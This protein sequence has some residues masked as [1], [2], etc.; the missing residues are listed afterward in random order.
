MTS[1]PTSED[2]MRQIWIP[3]PGPPEVLELREAPD[4]VPAHD[5]V[6]IRV[7]AA[8]VNFADIMGRMGMYPDL[9]RMPVVVGY[10][11]AGKID[12]FKLSAI[13]G[14]V[15][16]LYCLTLPHTPPA[17][18]GH[19]F[20]ISDALGLD[21]LAQMK[22]RSFA[23]FVIGS[24]LICIPLQFYYAF[25][26]LFLNESGVTNA[27]GKM[28]LGQMS[29]ILFMLLLPVFLMRFGT[30]NILLMGMA[31]WGARYLLFAHGNVGSGAW[32][33]YGGILLHGICYDF[34]FVTGQI[35]VDQQAS[36]KIRAAAQGFLTFLTQGV[37]YLIGSFASGVVVQ[38]FAIATGGHDW[39][40]IWLRPA[41]GAAIILVVFALVFRPD[42]TRKMEG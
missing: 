23:T 13:L 41:V 15:M 22:D 39:H 1:A 19:R 5:Q 27:A 34:F 30:K 42:E 8:G 11:V 32:M 9:P 33:L 18:V 10:E 3:R 36:V 16:G 2:R 37:G 4:P 20:N 26:N 38:Q 7:E 21:A 24:F 40:A 12:A 17:R 14:A 31:A 29:E 28:T 25:T 6:R 35:Y